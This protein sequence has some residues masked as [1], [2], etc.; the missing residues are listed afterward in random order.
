MLWFA[1]LLPE[2]LSFVKSSTRSVEV[3]PGGGVNTCSLGPTLPGSG[4]SP[5]PGAQQP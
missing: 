3:P 1:R 4:R 2:Q 5:E